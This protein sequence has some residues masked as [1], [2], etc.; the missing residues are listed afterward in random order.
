MDLKRTASTSAINIGSLAYRIQDSSD[1][2]FGADFDGDTKTDLIH[3]RD[4]LVRV[5]SMNSSNQLV[6]IASLSNSS[7]DKDK[8]ILLGDFNG[9]GKTDF[10]L[11]S[12]NN[13]TTWRFYLSRGTN[14]YYYSKNIGVK[15]EKNYRPGGS[16]NVNGVWMNDPLYEFHFIGQD[17]DGDSKTD[18]LKHEI[19]SPWQSI[20]LVS[21]RIQIYSNKHNSGQSTPSFSQ[22]INSLATNNGLSKFGIPVFLDA[23]QTN[24]N[25][26]YA[27]IVANDVYTYELNRDHKKEVT[28]KRITNNG[29]T[30]NIFYENLDSSG[31]SNTYQTDLSENYP[32]VNVNIVPSFKIVK[33]VKRTGS[34]KTQRQL[35]QYG[36]AV[37]HAKGLGFLGF[38]TFKKSN[39]FG[40][41]VGQLW[42]VSKHNPQKRGAI[43]QQ[44]V[45]TS[46]SSYLSSNFINKADYTYSSQLLSNKV[47]VN[48]PTQINK[49]DGLQ[50]ISTTESYTYDS[51][52]N[53][54]SISTTFSGG[55]NTV[56][57]QYSNNPT[58]TGS[59][60]HIGRTTK[61][62]ETSVLNGNSF[63]TEIQFAY[64]NNLLTQNKK[65]GNGTPWLI[66]SFTYDAFGNIK[67]KTVGGSGIA[68]RI[69]KFDYDNSGR[70]LTKS[71]DIEGLETTYTYN[72]ATGN[73]ITTTNPYGHTTTF[74]YDGWQRL[75]KK[76]NYLGKETNHYY[77]QEFISGIGQCF[78]KTIDYPEDQDEKTYYN[79]F[80]WKVQSKV[81][82]LNDKWVQKKFEYDAIGRVL[83]ESEPYFSD[84]SPTQ[85][86][87]SGYDQYGRLISQQLFTGKV[88][89]T[90]YN[91]L[92]VTVDD[93]TKSVT[94]KKN[95]SGN[96]A[97][98][99][100]LGGTVNYQYYGNGAMKSANYGS[101]TVSTTIDGWGR[102]IGLTDPSAGTYT[103]E[104]NILGEITKETTP[105]GET[106]YNYDAFGKLLTKEINGDKTALTVDYDYNGT[107]KLLEQINGDDD[108][109]N[110]Q[111]TYNYYYDSYHRPNKIR[112][113][114]NYV[115]FEKQMTYDA[116]GRINKDV[117][118]SKNLATGVNNTVQVKNI[119]DEAGILTEIRDYSSN[120][121]LW[122]VNNENA[123]GQT[124]EV[125][126]GNGI[127]KERQYDQ[128]GFLTKIT[129][130]DNSIGGAQAL[131]VDYNFDA[132]RNILLSRKNYAFTNW[133]ESFTYDNLDRLLSVSGPNPHTQNYDDQGRITD[134]SFVGDYTY[135]ND[136]QYRLSEIELNNQGDL[137]YQNHSL[138]QVS[139]NAFK[140]PVEILEKEKG[141]VSFEYGPMM[142]RTSSYYGGLEENK[143]DR[144]YHKRYSSIIPVEIVEDNNIGSTKIITYIGGDSYTAPIAQIKTN[145][146]NVD[147]NEYHY[148]HR[149]YLGSILAISN[150]G[151]VGAYVGGAA[152]GVLST[153]GISGGIIGGALSGIAGGIAGGLISGAGM[154]LLPGGNGDVL[155]KVL[156]KELFL[157]VLLEEHWGALQHLKGIVYGL[158]LS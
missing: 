157:V 125:E 115:E 32:F 85:W 100:D 5:Y 20:T 52:K 104:Y 72:T 139:Y 118:I 45:S 103:Y 145:G 110:T 95:A 127:I 148:L 86:N 6:Q 150:S 17:Y 16:I 102:K 99:E 152:L 2:L 108:E 87:T 1:K 112:E 116:F 136:S 75:L 19:V 82:S 22:T 13:S 101:H 58:S 144:R 121:L 64:S 55:S 141:R 35:Y 41:D 65:K 76:T 57:Y 132:Q 93:G 40:S 140:K 70:F 107:T 98:I 15:Y 96:I 135:N 106:T 124:L 38:K 153:V 43:T 44:W 114:T 37:A 129:D 8:P 154:A 122:K 142:N 26:E 23:K 126:L 36:G 97:V 123:R 113:V 63:T 34:G 156:Y 69:E 143:T 51:Y 33:E 53:P 94:T 133:N 73:P 21:D 92:S 78:T 7:I 25:L 111:Y 27:Y 120:N 9:D 134:N 84:E 137:Y 131:K 90:T 117:Y 48:V 79:V 80:G 14:I 119:Y 30:T 155:G 138:Q 54:L 3:I 91:G 109:T 62:V 39:W 88:I 71:T 83:R 128:Y 61:K 60:Y 77:N 12:A 18:I 49:E 149:D 46:P 66:E 68:N 42:N 11:P 47:F 28:L 151:G 105:K 4:G 29:T 130:K 81:L 89:N 10:T 67:Q 59:A 74:E 31:G 147:V 158:V 24:S 50:G 146:F 56:T